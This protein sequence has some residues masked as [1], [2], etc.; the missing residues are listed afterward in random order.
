[1]SSIQNRV[2]PCS[3]LRFDVTPDDIESEA[4]QICDR[5]SSLIDT[6]AHRADGNFTFANTVLPFIE[7]ENIR[8][9]KMRFLQFFKSTNPDPTLRAT[10]LHVSKL[11]VDAQLDLFVRPD[12]YK[13]ISAVQKKGEELDLEYHNFLRSLGDEFERNG[14]GLAKNPEALA[15]F[16]AIKKRL[17]WLQIET[18]HSLN[19]EKSGLWF[20]VD[21]LQGLP[22]NFFEKR[23]IQAEQPD[24]DFSEAN[25]KIWVTTKEA[26]W[27]PILKLAT[28]AESRKKMFLATQHRGTNN[29]PL[30]EEMFI[31]RDEAARLLGYEHHA[32]FQAHY[33]MVKDMNT[34]VTFLD[35]VEARLKSSRDHELDAM[36]QLKQNDVHSPWTADERPERLF[37]W[38]RNFYDRIR[39]EK[40]CSFDH[41][42]VTEY[43]SLQR[44]LEVML[45]TFE[46]LFGIGVQ[47]YKP[48]P[49]EVWHE[50]VLMY[51]IW[52]ADDNEAFLGWLY[53]DPYP[54]DG[55][56][57]HYGHYNLQ[58]VCISCRPHIHSLLKSSLGLHIPQWRTHPPLVRLSS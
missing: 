3:P 1:M 25:T 43:F 46:H 13:A 33:K 32:A 18:L 11:L 36:L 23:K 17:N 44:S 22:G 27:L 2:P 56:H 16:T 55:K 57:T 30:Y 41:I 20:S 7:A 14:M 49:G 51:T 5:T 39:K 4:K 9:Q 48:G 19:N 21:E 53:M 31:L 58:P 52:D 29:I 42:L 45:R 26:D 54:R 8:L 34:V 37:L 6:L 38:D 28:N 10:S 35:N 47:S 24:Q 12:F 40:E 50:D 15:R